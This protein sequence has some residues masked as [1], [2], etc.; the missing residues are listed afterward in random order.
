MKSITD[1]NYV[2]TAANCPEKELLLQTG[3]KN[4]KKVIF[5]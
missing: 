3:K 1:M 4:F 2:I 5:N